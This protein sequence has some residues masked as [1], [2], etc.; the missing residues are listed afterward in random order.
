MATPPG[1][2]AD[3][4]GQAE[5][6]WWD[7]AAWSGYTDAWFPRAD[8]DVLRGPVRAG[9]IAVL[10]ILAGLAISTVIALLLLLAGVAVDD[11]W[12]L[13]AS[14]AGL[15]VGLFGACWIAVHRKGSGSLR[16]LGLERFRGVDGAIGVGVGIGLVIVAAILGLLMQE[17]APQIVPKGRTDITDP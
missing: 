4:W 17:I 9:G 8:P 3:P 6:R 15:W 12:L 10:G 5:W 7:G 14:T 11:P 16:D 2:F 1:W 13:V